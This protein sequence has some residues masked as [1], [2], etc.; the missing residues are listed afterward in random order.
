VFNARPDVGGR[1]SVFTHFGL[2]PAAVMGIDLLKLLGQGNTSD[3]QSRKNVPYPANPN[4]MLGLVLGE[5][6][7]HGKDNWNN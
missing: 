5:A 7:K 2:V 6:A 4:L 1:Y 3:L